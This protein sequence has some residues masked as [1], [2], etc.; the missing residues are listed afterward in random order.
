MR[1]SGGYWKPESRTVNVGIYQ[2]WWT[3]KHNFAGSGS[4]TLSIDWL[5][6]IAEP[7]LQKVM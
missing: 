2:F 6:Q 3:D 1:Q 5:V 7:L 4:R